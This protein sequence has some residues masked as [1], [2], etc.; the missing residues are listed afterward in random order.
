MKAEFSVLRGT[1]RAIS[2]LGVCAKGLWHYY[3]KIRPAGQAD[4]QLVLAHWCQMVARELLNVL[5]VELVIKGVPPKGGMLACNHVSYLD[6]VVLAAS[7]PMTFV[8]K[9]QVKNWPIFGWFGRLS[10]T[11]FLR[12]EKKSHAVEISRQFARVIESGAVLVLFPEGTSTDG[13]HVKPFH[14]TLFEP[15]ARTGWPVTPGWI[16]YAVSHGSVARDI[17]FINAMLF[18]PHFARLLCRDGATATVVYGEEL[19]ANLSRKEIAAGLH[20]Q[21][22]R[23]AAENSGC[24]C[25]SNPQVEWTDPALEALAVSPG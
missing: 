8:S 20:R 2:F 10:G 22:C 14:S 24:E 11:L 1:A 9:Y 18:L 13:S 23:L 19:P 6:I 15:A 16:T 25:R 3:T 17:C 21:V 7:A 12:R 5:N 4:N